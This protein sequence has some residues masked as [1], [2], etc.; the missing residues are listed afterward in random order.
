MSL[1]VLVAFM[2]GK[3]IPNI[4]E[5][6]LDTC[7][8]KFARC[9]KSQRFRT[10]TS[11]DSDTTFRSTLDQFRET[12]ILLTVPWRCSGWRWLYTSVT[13]G[14]EWPRSFWTS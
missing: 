2:Q 3:D 7:L 9:L 8:L 1:F 10:R 4:Y 6:Q 11:I 14:D 5:N 12:V 13:L